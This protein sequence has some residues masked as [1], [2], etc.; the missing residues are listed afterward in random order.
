MNWGMFWA[1]LIAFFVRG[2]YR[3]IRDELKYIRRRANE[4]KSYGGL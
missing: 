4:L 2:A 1:I 3:Y